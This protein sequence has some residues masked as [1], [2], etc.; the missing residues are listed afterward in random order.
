MKTYT[1]IALIMCALVVGVNLWILKSVRAQSATTPDT[2]A[3]AWERGYWLGA[4]NGVA[5]AEHQVMIAQKGSPPDRATFRTALI[6]GLTNNP[7][8]SK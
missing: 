7:Y 2:L 6:Q 1:K 8:L 4:S 5:A 3:Q